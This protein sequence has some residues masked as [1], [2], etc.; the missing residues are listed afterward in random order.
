[1]TGL[2]ADAYHVNE[3]QNLRESGY[4]EISFQ[5]VQQEGTRTAGCVIVRS[6]QP[7]QDG[8]VGEVVDGTLPGLA[9]FSHGSKIIV[10]HGV[11]RIMRFEDT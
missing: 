6:W 9:I 4:T 8:C 2:F 5:A 11:Q 1:M 3:Y 10:N 7:V